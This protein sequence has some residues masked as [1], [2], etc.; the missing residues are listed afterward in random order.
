[1][2]FSIVKLASEID[3]GGKVDVGVS[4]INGIAIASG[5]FNRFLSIRLTLGYLS[6][7][8]NCFP[9]MHP[10]VHQMAAWKC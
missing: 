8:I 6:V 10:E 1:M 7:A 5:P 9:N 4:R 3:D 2:H